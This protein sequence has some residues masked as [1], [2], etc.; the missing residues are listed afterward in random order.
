MLCC[1]K[2]SHHQQE[3]CPWV[4]QKLSQYTH[5]T[6]IETFSVENLPL[7]DDPIMLQSGWTIE[8]MKSGTN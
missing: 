6:V 2:R 1:V 8:K 4:R 7:W 3:V 5:Y